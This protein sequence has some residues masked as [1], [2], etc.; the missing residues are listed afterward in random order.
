MS[1]VISRNAAYLIH[2]DSLVFQPNTVTM[3]PHFPKYTTVTN[4]PAIKFGD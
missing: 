4:T 3:G 2:L 1:M